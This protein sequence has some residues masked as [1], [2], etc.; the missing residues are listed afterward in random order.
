LDEATR[1]RLLDETGKK[2]SAAAAHYAETFHAPILSSRLA[3]KIETWTALATAFAAEPDEKR[4]NVMGRIAEGLASAETNLAQDVDLASPIA[5][6]RSASA[7]DEPRAYPFAAAIEKLEI[8]NAPR[9][10]PPLIAQLESLPKEERAATMN[11]F[12]EADKTVAAPLV[13]AALAQQ[14]I[15]G[16]EAHRWAELLASDPQWNRR[17]DEQPDLKAQIDAAVR[18]IQEPYGAL[19]GPRPQ[20]GPKNADKY[21]ELI[22]KSLPG[23]SK[24]KTKAEQ[25]WAKLVESAKAAKGKDKLIADAHVAYLTAIRNHIVDHKPAP[26]T[27]ETFDKQETTARAA[28]EKLKADAER[29]ARIAAAKA[30]MS[31]LPLSATEQS[32]TAPEQPARGETPEYAQTAE[33]IEGPAKAARKKKKKSKAKQP[34]RDAAPAIEKADANDLANALIQWTEDQP[35]AAALHVV[36]E[37]NKH[38]LADLLLTSS[39]WDAFLPNEHAEEIEQSIRKMDRAMARL[40]CS[41]AA[42]ELP[43]PDRK[44]LASYIE[45]LATAHDWIDF[46]SRMLAWTAL[47]RPEIFSRKH[48]ACVTEIMNYVKHSK[49]DPQGDLDDWRKR[50]LADVQAAK[51]E[52]QK[53]QKKALTLA[54]LERLLVARQRRQG[55]AASRLTE[56]EVAELCE[57][58]SGKK[59]KKNQNPLSP[60]L[61]DKIAAMS[62]E[63]LQEDLL[64][65]PAMNALLDQRIRDLEQHDEAYRKQKEL[66]EKLA[67][68]QHE[69]SDDV[70]PNLISLIRMYL[71]A[72]F[73]LEKAG[74]DKRKSLNPEKEWRTAIK[75]AVEKAHG[76]KAFS[77]VTSIRDYFSSRPFELPPYIEDARERVIGDLEEGIK[78]L[79]PVGLVDRAGIRDL[80]DILKSHHIL[81]FVK[82]FYPDKQWTK[83]GSPDQKADAGVA[84]EMANEKTS[85][86]PETASE[87]NEPAQVRKEALEPAFIE[88]IIQALYSGSKDVN[89]ASALVENALKDYSKDQALEFLI[90]NKPWRDRTIKTNYSTKPE[91]MRRMLFFVNMKEHLE[92]ET[93]KANFKSPSI[94]KSVRDCTAIALIEHRAWRI[95]YEFDIF[96]RK[97]AAEITLEYF[98]QLQSETMIRQEATVLDGLPENIVAALRS[99]NELD[100]VLLM[101]DAAERTSLDT[102]HVAMLSAP[103]WNAFVLESGDNKSA[104]DEEDEELVEGAE[105]CLEPH[106]WSVRW[107]FEEEKHKALIIE[108]IEH[109]QSPAAVLRILAMVMNT[110]PIECLT[111]LAASLDASEA[112]RRFVAQAPLADSNVIDVLAEATFGASN[113]LDPEVFNAPHLSLSDANRRFFHEL[114]QQRE[115]A[116]TRNVVGSAMAEV[117]GQ[118]GRPL[119]IPVFPGALPTKEFIVKAVSQI[120]NS[121]APLRKIE[122]TMEPSSYRVVDEK[123]NFDDKEF[124]AGIR[125]H[126]RA[127]LHAPGQTASSGSTDA[128]LLTNLPMPDRCALVTRDAGGK[129]WIAA[130]EGKLGLEAYFKNQISAGKGNALS[131]IELVYVK[132]R[133]A[134]ITAANTEHTAQRATPSVQGKKSGKKI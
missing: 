130:R 101:K 81:E 20:I 24:S 84:R 56:E 66:L 21:G 112:W 111:M 25:E 102:V 117:I 60:A 8:A 134:Q 43:E 91:A 42:S 36:N 108:F 1:R 6:L 113:V 28:V 64:S 103:A 9:K 4:L 23:K 123:G 107:I 3:K 74:V 126:L 51:E 53:R 39:A 15:A 75:A 47:N 7:L 26:E 41:L 83:S 48:H 27:L 63:E 85:A 133:V 44:H 96:A 77:C 95:D 132:G 116:N 76:E 2:L 80:A 78:H 93:K 5:A 105:E 65:S 109:D 119:P 71:T 57:V 79:Q 92:K 127:T 69:L 86:P 22:K 38:A 94:L 90:K 34:P 68:L 14:L 17:L 99:G 88:E 30:Y 97:A 131:N 11:G 33:A 72:K 70:E 10:V 125:K 129:L 106:L 120:K 62:F 82:K 45:G 37:D 13:A 114:V 40:S 87:K 67:I 16:D 52:A 100:A 55:Q 31:R 124:S 35:L 104:F 19:L 50:A 73:N 118:P 89:A 115:M 32:Q 46:H 98:P 18:P 110:K 54:H 128:V 29:P 59:L 122:L 49:S 61:A 12:I 58:M 121:V